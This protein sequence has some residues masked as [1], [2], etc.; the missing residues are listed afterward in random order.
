M[1]KVRYLKK[2]V[3]FCLAFP[4]AFGVGGLFVC[5]KYGLD[6]TGIVQA[7]IT[8]YTVELGLSCITRALD[9]KEERINER[10][11]DEADGESAVR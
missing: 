5:W 9:R 6:P 2:V 11:T 4:A 1:S 3:T 10:E 8:A 7:V